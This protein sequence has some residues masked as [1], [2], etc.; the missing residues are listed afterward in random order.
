MDKFAYIAMTGAKHNA[1]AI[2]V[3]SNNLANVLTT[4]FRSDFIHARSMQSFG[5]SFPSRVYSQAE[6]PST[7][8]DMGQLQETG[9]GLDVAIEGDGFIAVEGRDG[10]E[11]F[12]RA[13]D[14]VIDQLGNL[15]TATGSPVLGEGGPIVIPPFE[16]LEIGSDGTITIQ[17]KG[18]GP[19][20]LNQVNRIKLVDPDLLGLKKGEDGFFRRADGL[21]EPAA[22]GMQLST[23]FLETSNVNA[24]ESLTQI[25]AL[26]RQFEMQIKMIRTAEQN[27]ETSSK[28]LQV[29]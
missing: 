23:G 11:A 1:R 27:D 16:K 4:G 24:V 22:A 28:L 12:T 18:Q 6:I 20:N 14:L 13:G 21:I 2:A 5:E 17:G 3:Q 8:F 19:E 10:A 29:N 26:S 7:K 9:R 15:R 25:L